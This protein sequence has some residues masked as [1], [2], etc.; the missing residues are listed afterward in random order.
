MP[1][2]ATVGGLYPTRPVRQTLTTRRCHPARQGRPGSACRGPARWRP[3]SLRSG[4]PPAWCGSTDPRPSS[5]R[6]LVRRL[7]RP[8]HRGAT[9]PMSLR[10]T[11]GG[12]AAGPVLHRHQ[13]HE[14]RRPAQ[15]GSLQRSQ[16]PRGARQDRSD[17][18]RPRPWYRAAL[19]PVLAAQVPATG[20]TPTQPS[21]DGLTTASRSARNRT[22][23]TRG[24]R[25]AAAS[26]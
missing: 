1:R 10:P 8:P 6:T 22:S 11:G 17:H 25:R 23:S 15:R 5:R 16:T 26:V 7:G 20:S 2:G 14:D 13:W 3:P 24:P 21:T 4:G 18:G 9:A 12:L 19:E